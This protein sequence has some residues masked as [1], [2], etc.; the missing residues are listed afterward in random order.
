MLKP[1]QMLSPEKIMA[2]WQREKLD[3]TAA[4]ILFCVSCGLHGVP[5]T[6][7]VADSD[8]LRDLP[9]YRLSELVSYGLSLAWEE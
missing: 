3:T 8:L 4:Q 5:V 9:H 2:L 6:F 1:D 7:D